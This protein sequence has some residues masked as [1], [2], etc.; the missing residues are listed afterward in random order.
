[1]RF[2]KTA[3]AATA[4]CVALTGTALAQTFS[5][6]ALANANDFLYRF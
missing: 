5:V 1:M 3:F 2:G 6:H 4:L